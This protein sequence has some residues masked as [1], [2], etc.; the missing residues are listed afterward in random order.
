MLSLADIEAIVG[1]YHDS[2]MTQSVSMIL[3]RDY[4][5]GFE[6]L[7]PY[8]SKSL[9]RY[10]IVHA[11]SS[12]IK[13]IYKAYPDLYS[14]TVI[15]ENNLGTTLRSILSITKR[16]ELLERVKS[17]MLFMPSFRPA[18]ELAEYATYAPK[19]ETDSIIEYFVSG[20]V[21]PTIILENYTPFDLQSDKIVKLCVEKGANYGGRGKHLILRFAS[22]GYVKGLKALVDYYNTEDKGKLINKTITWNSI[23]KDRYN[24]NV[25]DYLK[26]VIEIDTSQK[27]H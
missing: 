6:I 5:R 18:A 22:I 26:T 4:F 10:V 3:K 14:S 13:Y 25:M 8:L 20:G 24:K 21:D 27:F 23:P 9:L 16:S 17:I 15:P 2:F 7:F 1:R 11:S 12:I 19:Q